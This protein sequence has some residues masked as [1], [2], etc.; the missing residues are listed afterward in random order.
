MRRFERLSGQNVKAL[1]GEVE[2]EAERL[3]EIQPPH[4]FRAH[5]VDQ[6]QAPPRGIMHF[7]VRVQNGKEARSVYKDVLL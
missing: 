1:L 6:A 2:V 3:R 4:D 7:I 5:D